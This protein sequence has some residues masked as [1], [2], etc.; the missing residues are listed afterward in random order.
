MYAAGFIN[1]LYNDY[2][3]ALEVRILNKHQ[4]Q[5]IEMQKQI[6]LEHKNDPHSTQYTTKEVEGG[7]IIRKNN[8][9]LVPTTLRMQGMDWYHNILVHPGEHHT[10][11]SIRPIYVWKGLR[12]NILQYCK[13]VTSTEILENT[14]KEI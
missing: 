3:F 14:R 2:E 1:A 6:S 12:T 10:E 5:D 11:E 4:Q 8:R 9:I 7:N 13:C